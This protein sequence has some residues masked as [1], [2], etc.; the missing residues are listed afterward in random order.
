[1]DVRV[2]LWRM[3]SA[4]KLMLLNCGIGEDSWESLG[5]QG[6]PTSPFWRRSA[7][8][9]LWKHWCW[10][11]NSNTLATSCEEL[12]HWKRLWCWEGLGAGREGDDRGWDGGMA[13]LSRWTWVWMN[14][15]SWLWTG[16]PGM[17]WFMWLQ[18][19]G[20]DWA[21]ELNL[22]LNLYAEYIMSNAYLCEVQTG[23]KIPERNIKKNP[24]I[25][26]W[27]HPHGRKWRGTK[28]PLD[29][30][31]RGEWNIWLRL[32]VQ[33]TNIMAFGPITLWQIDG[34]IMEAV[35]N[36]FWGAPKSLQMMT[37]AMKIIY[38]YMFEENLWET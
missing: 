24:Q 14:S 3:L 28:E 26:R 30:S 33:K 21:T 8:G 36:L 1:M 7:L 16:K 37:A 10:S 35:R 27:H 22:S 9:F 4:E 32:P 6:D 38:A 25:C 5:L 31:E 17:L 29:E 11:W 15:R 13:S 2:G 23:I 19:V 12:T 34:E 18:R 20:H